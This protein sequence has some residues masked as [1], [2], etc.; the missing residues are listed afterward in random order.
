MRSRSLPR[1]RSRALRLLLTSLAL[2]FWG[3]ARPAWA[4]SPREAWRERYE[5]AKAALIA[6]DTAK[7]AAELAELAKQAESVEDRRL[8]EELG[9]VARARD[10]VSPAPPAPRI[11]TSDELSIL[12]TSAFVYGLGTSAWV[13]LLLEP[14]NLAGAGLPFVLL[15][16][17]AVGGVAVADGYR[18]LRRGVPHS[19][20]TGLYLGLVEG[21]WLVGLEHAGATRRG[22][23]SRWSSTTVATVLWAGSTAGGLMGGLVGAWREPTPGRTSFAGSAAIWPGLTAGFVGAALEG[24]RRR[25]GEVAFLSG[26]IAYNLGIAAGIAVAPSVAPSVSRMRFVDLGAV[27]G[28]LL[29]AGVYAVAAE[30]SAN[31]RGGLASTAGGIVGGLGLA[32]WLT[33]GMPRDPPANPPPVASLRPIIVPN[34]GGFLAGVAGDL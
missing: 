17:A 28:G 4:A 7:A 30:S 3:I 24:D 8:A 12:Y 1:S 19:L 9:A 11:R 15:T 6:G 5:S 27:G 2:Y 31:V 20:A 32:W 26:G 34:D 23:G 14:K 25:R 18:P 21:A 29:G 33:R 16:S 13:V 10:T 22:D